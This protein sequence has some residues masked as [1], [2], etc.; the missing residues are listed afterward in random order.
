MNEP[1]KNPD[2]FN[3]P[4]VDPA[5]EL[6][7]PLNSGYAPTMQAQTNAWAVISL[8]S[9]VLAWVGLFGVGGVVGVIAGIVARNQIKASNGA[10]TG[11]GI[12]LAG[13]ILGATNI[14]IT[15][16]GILCVMAIFGASIFGAMASGVKW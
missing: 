7:P 14:A 2:E 16:I 9:S 1:N 13:I 4:R 11:D 10:Q 12:A 3:L 15:C 8:V 6:P 5:P